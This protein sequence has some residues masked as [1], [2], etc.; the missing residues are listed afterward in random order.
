MHH[1]L[2]ARLN[3]MIVTPSYYDAGRA[4]G[5]KQCES[6][7][8]HLELESLS[9]NVLILD[10]TKVAAGK[11]STLLIV[12]EDVGVTKWPYRHM[13][14]TMPKSRP[15]SPETEIPVSSL[16]KMSS[17]SPHRKK[18]LGCQAPCHLSKDPCRGWRTPLDWLVFK[19]LPSSR[20]EGSKTI[21]CNTD[22]VHVI[23]TKEFIPTK[24]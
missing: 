22:S 18:I 5:C 16:S 20:Q 21:N 6:V 10:Q 14:S 7:N 15:F 24:T 9:Y 19:S 11:P 23:I 13:R 3:G 8:T 17:R 1:A 2:C 12:S 4:N